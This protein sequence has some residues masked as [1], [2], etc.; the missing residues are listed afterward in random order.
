MFAD[1]LVPC[2]GRN[3]YCHEQFFEDFPDISDMRILG[4]DVASA[5]FLYASGSKDLVLCTNERYILELHKLL[6]LAPA[7]RYIRECWENEFADGHSWDKRCRKLAAFNNRSRRKVLRNWNDVVT[8]YCILAMSSFSYQF[9]K[10]RLVSEHV[11]MTPDYDAIQEWGKVQRGKE[12]LFYN[13]SVYRFPTT[14]LNEDTL[15]YI[16]LPNSFAAY[17]CGYVWSK[18][19]L[20]YISAE[21]NQFARE[22]YKICVSARHMRL[23]HVVNKYPQ[24]FDQ[25]LFKPYYYTQ[26]KADRNINLPDQEVYL[27]ANL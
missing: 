14:L 8:Y 7:H 18:R 2:P 1:S 10:W 9:K 16:H 12:M 6:T 25:D 23:G 21:L 3:T 13:K 19:K 17:G 5:D 15:M 4:I 26:L 20:E 22:G 24:Y 27:V 11:P